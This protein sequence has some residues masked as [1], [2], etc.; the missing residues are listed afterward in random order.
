MDDKTK[1]QTA[2]HESGHVF[3]FIY[4]GHTFTAVDIT[5]TENRS[6]YGRVSGGK[7]TIEWDELINFINTE[8][9][10]E[11]EKKMRNSIYNLIMICLAGYETE[12]VFEIYNPDKDNE[13]VS[14]DYSKVW[15]LAQAISI[16][17]DKSDTMTVVDHSRKELRNILL[18]NKLMLEK[19]TNVLMK[20][21]KVSF[22]IL[23]ELVDA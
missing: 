3:M 4:L 16:R 17:Y 9:P 13:F 12:R 19:I 7:P 5:L 10:I 1:Y 18:E 20:S 8:I 15:D 23:K 6:R 11:E 21:D 2:I 22:D 14:F